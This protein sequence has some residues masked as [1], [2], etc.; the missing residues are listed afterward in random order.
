MIIRKAEL[1]DVFAVRQLVL[2]LAHVFLQGPESKDGIAVP[3][4]LPDAFMASLAIEEF[5]ARFNDHQYL[6]LV[7]EENDEISGYGAL[8]ANSHLFHLFVAETHQG[9]GISRLLWHQ[10]KTSVPGQITVNSSL[11]AVP[12]YRKLGF[13]AMGGIAEKNGIWFQLMEYAAD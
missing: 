11:Y 8:R 6:N 13:V 3:A 1:N 12:V 7:C 9:K 5:E 2:S 4:P 10:L